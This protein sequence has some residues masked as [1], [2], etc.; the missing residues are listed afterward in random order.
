MTSQPPLP[1]PSDVDR[2][3]SRA[4]HLPLIGTTPS[5]TPAAIPARMLNEVMYCE[6]LMYLEWVQGE[7]SDNYFT[8][9]GRAVHDRADTPG[10]RLP[11]PPAADDGGDDESADEAANADQ[12]SYQARS[13]WLTSESLGITAKIDVVEGEHDGSVVPIEYKRGAAPRVPEYAYLPERIQLCAQVLLLREHGYQ[14]DHGE[15]YFA[16][17]KQRVSIAMSDEL[18]G[19]TQWA[20]KLAREVA[21]RTEPPPPLRDSPKCR[22]CSLVG[23]CLPDEVNLLRRL[24]GQNI[25]DTAEPESDLV[26]PLH[27]DPWSLVGEPDE[28]EQPRV[29]RLY[30]A[31]DDRVPVYVQ[32]H[33]AQIALSGERLVIRG[34]NGASHVR[35][36]N[37][38]HV[39]IRGNVQLSTQAARALLDRGIPVL[40]LTGGGWFSGRLSGTDTNN[41][42]LRMAQYR[43]ALEPKRCLEL[44]RTFV[45]AKLRNARTMLRRN[46]EQADEVTLGQLKQLTRKA[47]H[48]ENLESL[49]GIEG[50]AARVYFQSFAGMLRGPVS[51]GFDFERRNR[52]PPRDPVNALLSFAYSLL[53]KELVIALASAGLEPLL[54]FYHQRRF[55][56]PALALDLMEEFRPLIG[57]SVVIS[58][59]NTGVIGPADFIRMAGACTIK[60][61]ARKR[62][63]EAYE[64]RLDQTIVHPVFGN[65]SP[66]HGLLSRVLLGELEDYPAFVTR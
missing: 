49:L 44:A 7:F 13:V 38:S 64:R 14:C 35:L 51:G 53:T 37:T 25:E 18:M 10:G 36:M 30:A 31:R 54:G 52:R 63:I 34:E 8:V 57:D 17:S 55:G 19:H 1:D 61:H 42:D 5:S 22:G 50:A 21:S 40:Y 43:T 27:P 26:G 32:D 41:I 58:A 24:D 2:D 29:R 16:K 3:Q 33:G 4:K 65:T 56:R 6:R 9:E 23:I 11:K 20:M 12:Q 47:K 28:Q 66:M 48:C 46:H 62:F 60:D 59:I 45:V 15:I 39:V